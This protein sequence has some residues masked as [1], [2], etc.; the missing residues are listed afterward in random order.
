MIPVGMAEHMISRYWKEAMDDALE[1]TLPSNDIFHV[2]WVYA[3]LFRVLSRRGLGSYGLEVRNLNT[4]DAGRIQ[5]E[6][7]H[8]SN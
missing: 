1:E 2:L 7:L 4:L 5:R 3:A 6:I 8:K